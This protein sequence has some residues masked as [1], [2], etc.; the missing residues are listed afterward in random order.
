MM[1]S[2]KKD[3]LPFRYAWFQMLEGKKI[4]L[5]SWSGYWA[6]ENN[7]IMMHCRDGSVL[8]IR[9]TDNPAYTFSNVASDD[10]MVIDDDATT[11]S[12]YLH[13]TKTDT[14]YI[15]ELENRAKELE[16]QIDGAER[17]IIRL[18]GEN[19]ALRFAIRCNGVSGAEVVE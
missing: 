19:S 15:E 14:S 17:R 1:N 18:E 11:D 4:K 6:W 10:W 7:T 3:T 8:D 5:P 2:S 16:F 12:E 9:E 13:E